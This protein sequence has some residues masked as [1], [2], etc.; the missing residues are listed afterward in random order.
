MVTLDTL[1]VHIPLDCITAQ[2][3]PSQVIVLSKKQ[4]ETDRHRAEYGTGIGIK[5]LKHTEG[6]TCL[7]L[8]ASA[9]ALTDDYLKGIS[10]NTIEQFT[11][12]I[13]RQTGIGID[14]DIWLNHPDAT[15]RKVDHCQ[16]VPLAEL[17]C[18]A[19]APVMSALNS[20][21]IRDRYHKK[22]FTTTG[23]VFTGKQKEKHRLTV[24]DKYAELKTAKQKD[25][26]AA[27]NN[28]MQVLTQAQSIARV[29]SNLTK[30]D[31]IRTRFGIERNTIGQVLNAKGN[32][33]AYI[34]EKMMT[35]GQLELFADF[36]RLMAGYSQASP[37]DFIKEMGYPVIIEKA[38]Y[39]IN[40]IRDLFKQKLT[41]QA[42]AYHWQGKNG[43]TK[44]P[45]EQ[46]FRERIDSLLKGANEDYTGTPEIITRLMEYLKAA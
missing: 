46:V 16:N 24:Y 20:L 34:L 14:I 39:N 32:P 10:L 1:T 30:F 41:K 25:F 36:D 29:E 26:R 3:E 11:N 13:E 5:A 7:I 27:L 6:D 42:F 43:N 44:K 33:N 18:T 37:I 38:A 12:S 19:F 45:F 22:P 2:P 17:G 23:I 21:E 35:G 31:S 28:P 15:I 8:E 9:K 4:G 40:T